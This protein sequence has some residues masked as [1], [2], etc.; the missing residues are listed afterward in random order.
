MAEA[1]KILSSEAFAASQDEIE[2]FL[3]T[4]EQVLVAQKEQAD[5]ESGRAETGGDLTYPQEERQCFESYM[6]RLQETR[7]QSDLKLFF[8]LNDHV[9]RQ[10]YEAAVKAAGANPQISKRVRGLT[11]RDQEG[12]DASSAEYQSLRLLVD[13]RRSL[14][15]P[16]QPNLMKDERRNDLRG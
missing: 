15:L 12:L 5:E 10:G 4:L 7:G 1:A 9:L 16:S 2:R 11:G 13:S 6:G 8:V 14:C 3:G